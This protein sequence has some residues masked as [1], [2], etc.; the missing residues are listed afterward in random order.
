M[1]LERDQEIQ[2]WLRIINIMGNVGGWIVV[3]VKMEVRIPSIH[4]RIPSIHIRIPSIH[5]RIPSIH[6]VFVYGVVNGTGGQGVVVGDQVK[7]VRH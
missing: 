2:R 5:I 1:D 6:I 7:K 3:G 4:I